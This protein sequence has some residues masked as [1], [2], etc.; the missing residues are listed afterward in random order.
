MNKRMLPLF[1]IFVL[2]MTA[3]GSAK[4]SESD[5]NTISVYRLVRPEYQADSGLLGTESFTYT[6]DANMVKAASLAIKSNPENPKLVSALPGNVSIL[7]AELINRTVDVCISDAYREISG[8]E[9]TLIECCIALTMCSIPGVDFVSIHI[10][11]EPSEMKL[12]SEDILLHN[13]LTSSEVAQVRLYFPKAHSPDLGAEYRSV[14]IS[15]ETSPELCVLNELLKGPTSDKLLPALPEDSVLLSVFTQD[16]LCTVTFSK[17][18][19]GALE[20]DI[21]ARLAIYSIVNSLTSLSTIE[22]VQIV[23]Q[24]SNLQTLGGVDISQPLNKKT[25]MIG[26]AIID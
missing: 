12:S 19:L 23:L 11:N 8:T 9:K 6:E 18:F 14:N 10:V 3:C 24:N 15:D 13:T 26:S 16:G 21:Q 20:S 2:L 22:S 17:D 4:T 7:S 25:S 1:I 5:T